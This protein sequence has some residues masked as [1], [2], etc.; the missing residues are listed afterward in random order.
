MTTGPGEIR[1]DVNP[2]QVKPVVSEP[3]LAQA[4]IA[5]AVAAD[6]NLETATLTLPKE[7]LEYLRS[8]A[9]KR[10]ISTG[11]MVRVAIGTQKFL[12][13]KTAAGA[14]VQI[15]DNSGTF[16]LAV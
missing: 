10:N 4:A 11:D 1:L 13:E 3:T 7:A 8:E 14:K 16:D 15:K 2:E 5:A 9:Q 12:S 6:P